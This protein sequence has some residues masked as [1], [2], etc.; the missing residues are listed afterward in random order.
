V[1]ALNDQ[2]AE[3]FDEESMKRTLDAMRDVLARRFGMA[4]ADLSLDRE[5][6]SL[7]LDSLAFFEYAFEIEEELDITLPDLPRDMVTIGDF[8]RFVHGEVLRKAALRP[9][10]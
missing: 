3:A 9:S 2:S 8:A 7:G 4:S 6:T 10:T 1:E 5:L